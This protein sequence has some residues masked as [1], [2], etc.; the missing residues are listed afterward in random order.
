MKP[1]LLV[2]SCHLALSEVD[3][4]GRDSILDV[5]DARR[6][7]NR[8][9]YERAL[10]QPREDDLTTRS[11]EKSMTKADG[12]RTAPGY[13]YFLHSSFGFHETNS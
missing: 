11:L 5:S 2:Q 9:Q 12:F 6:I 1:T 8:E 3:I 10:E 13:Q 7:R 4:A